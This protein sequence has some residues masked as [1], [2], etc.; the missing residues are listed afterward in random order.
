VDIVATAD[1][2][3]LSLVHELK[4]EF[5]EFAERTQGGWNKY[6]DVL[7]RGFPG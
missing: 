7:E 2:C 3:E 6:L 5:A 4:P 1:G